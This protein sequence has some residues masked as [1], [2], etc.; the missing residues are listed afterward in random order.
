MLTQLQ[1]QRTRSET[2]SPTFL[3][4]GTDHNYQLVNCSL[5][6]SSTPQEICLKPVIS[7]WA[8][9]DK[10][11]RGTMSSKLEVWCVKGLGCYQPLRLILDAFCFWTLTHFRD[12]KSGYAELSE[13]NTEELPENNYKRFSYRLELNELHRFSESNMTSSH[14]LVLSHFDSTGNGCVAEAVLFRLLHG[15]TLHLFSLIFLRFLCFY[16]E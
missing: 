5:K 13:C 10:P 12:W 6:S 11:L 9:V 15:C 7:V 3:L 2:C 8:S 14:L 16:H 4:R 1:E